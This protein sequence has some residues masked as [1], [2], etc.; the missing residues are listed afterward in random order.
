MKPTMQTID[1]ES[2]RPNSPSFP[3][4]DFNYHST[5]LGA[6]RGGCVRTGESSFHNISR[7]YFDTEANHHFLVEAFVFAAIM[8]TALVPLVNGAHAVL[9]L[10][11][12]CGGI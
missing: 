8:L 12:A 2:R 7:E 1:R 5:A 10:V 3:V 11:R 4:T 9:N 6:Y